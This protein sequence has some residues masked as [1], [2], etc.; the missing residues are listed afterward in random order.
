MKRWLMAFAALAVL[1]SACGGASSDG[2]AT[3]DEASVALVEDIEDAAS[4][5]SDE[6]ALLA[7]S[8][9]MRENGV[10]NFQDPVVDADGPVGV[11]FGRGGG[12]GQDGGPVRWRDQEAGRAPCVETLG[13]AEAQVH[14]RNGG[15]V[16]VG[17]ESR[18]DRCALLGTRPP[19][20]AGE[21][22]CRITLRP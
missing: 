13:S 22:S 11:G 19:R 7:F 1:A 12:G 14:R 15:E 16:G 9:C 3:L 21:D 4:G 6:E 5:I 18:A 17:Y 10:E 2:V 20:R 8:Q